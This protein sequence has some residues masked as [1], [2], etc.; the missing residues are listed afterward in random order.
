[1]AVEATEAEVAGATWSEVA[2]HCAA[3]AA[4]SV[5]LARENQE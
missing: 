3:S 5:S 4:M 1:M 2:A